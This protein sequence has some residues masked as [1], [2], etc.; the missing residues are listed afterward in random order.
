MGADK[1]A[2]RIWLVVY[3]SVHQQRRTSVFTNETNARQFFDYCADDNPEL[4]VSDVNFQL[5]T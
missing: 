4:Y 3:T 2:T 5:T 1:S